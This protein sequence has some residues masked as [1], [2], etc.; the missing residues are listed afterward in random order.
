M[1]VAVLPACVAS[2]EPVVDEDTGRVLLERT[3]SAASADLGVARW[4]VTEQVDQT[5]RFAG[6]DAAGALRVDAIARRDTGTPDERVH[7]EIVRPEPGTFELTSAGT[8]ECANTPSQVALAAALLADLGERT[9][10]ALPPATRGDDTASFVSV[11]QEGHE[12]FEGGLFG[13]RVNKTVAW[14]CR[15]GNRDHAVAYSNNGASCWVI[16]WTTEDASD[17][18]IQLHYGASPFFNDVCNWFV[19]TDK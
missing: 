1:M 12:Y 5:M 16:Q 7:V 19:Y 18:R 3:A 15:Q 11:D 4:T 13:V 14:F 6:R 8:I 9:G 10:T 2:P 17:C